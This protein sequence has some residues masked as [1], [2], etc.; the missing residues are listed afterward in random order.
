MNG[1][2]PESDP[3]ANAGPGG[4]TWRFGNA[5]LHADTME[6]RV[7]GRILALE[8][9]PKQVLL[10]LLQA[11]PGLVSKD[12]LIAQ[13]WPGRVI[14]D[15]ALTSCVAKL[16]NA[17]APVDGVQIKT[18]HGFGYR[19]IGPVQRTP[20]PPP[21]PEMTDDLAGL[22]RKPQWARPRALAAG[23]ILA[24]GAIAFLLWQ[25]AELPSPEERSVAV[26]PFAN[27]SLDPERNAYKAHSLHDNVIG[28]LAQ[29]EGLRVIS[30]TSTLQ[31]ENTRQPL[32]HIAVE[33]GVEHILE[34]SF[35]ES[36]GR[37][38][39]ITQ[40]IDAANDSHLWSNTYDR[41]ASDLMTLQ[42]EIAGAVAREIGMQLGGDA[43]QRLG[44]APHHDSATYDRYLQ[45]LSRWRAD[46]TSATPLLE[47][48]A[49][50]KRAVSEAPDFAQAWALLSRVHSLLHWFGHDR[51]DARVQLAK[52]A[53]DQALAL[54]PTLGEAHLAAGLYRSTGFGDYVGALQA[55]QKAVELQPGSAET[56][57]YLGSAH[58]R[59]QA[60]REAVRHFD[61][62]IALDPLNPL[63]LS[64]LAQFYAGLRL[65]QKAKP[66]Y[67]R[68]AQS[69]ETAFF[70]LLMRAYFY[71]A[72]LQDHRPMRAVLDSPA[73]NDHP[74]MRRF[75]S[76][77]LASYENRHA[78]A[79]AILAALPGDWLP[80]GGG[81]IKKSK[82]L[83]LGN[84]A[85][86]AGD[87][88]RAK[89]HF[90]KA[91]D[92]A[93]QQV[94]D[95]PESAP[96]LLDLASALAGLQQGDAA[97]PLIDRALA[98]VPRDHDPVMH[99]INAYKAGILLLRIGQADRGFDL[100]TSI[101]D[102]PYSPTADQL[103]RF[104]VMAQFRDDPR[105]A[106]LLARA[107]QPVTDL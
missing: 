63:Y 57:F 23:L 52:E 73:A 89:E 104:Q 33:L 96:A 36:D 82:A 17:L 102:L 97:A 44:R 70:P 29:L 1:A 50:L 107:D 93:Q 85:R 88:A 20:A 14:S 3:H 92:I 66:L 34:G 28:R 32:P 41:P 91:L 72:Y 39:V 94:T 49:L 76:H 24:A 16:R 71:S 60:Y 99:S 8:R 2:A 68:L 87:E 11:A 37:I 78:D 74:V 25:P 80:S 12:Q 79:L 5:S 43:A 35:Q 69:D 101:M 26:L 19:L 84:L 4:D 9:K 54:D 106:K 51:S 81:T 45:A 105:L 67:D 10:C 30:R 46:G 83:A 42:T 59:Q 40:L 15:S 55:Y 75:A 100:L 21:H 62:A 95:H 47:A 53:A 58:R 77:Q 86:Y 56:H 13:A 65:P 61:K 98:L 7:D 22:S 103:R 31:F 48:R 27:L 6:L 38:R 90:R 18:E 64:D